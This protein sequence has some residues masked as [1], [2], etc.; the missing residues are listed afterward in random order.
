MVQLGARHAL[1][2]IPF[3]YAL[4]AYAIRARPSPW[5]VLLFV[6]SIA[7]GIVELAVWTWA[8]KLVS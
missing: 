4:M 6:W 1:D 2:F 8:P 7:F 3:L 5:Y